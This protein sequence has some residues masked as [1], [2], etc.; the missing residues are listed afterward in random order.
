MGSTSIPVPKILPSFTKPTADKMLSQKGGVFSWAH[1][2]PIE[3]VA[4]GSWFRISGGM[5]RW[6]FAT[7]KGIT[8]LPAYVR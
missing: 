7:Q 5:T 3:V 6:Y 1:Y 2:T 4:E 8:H